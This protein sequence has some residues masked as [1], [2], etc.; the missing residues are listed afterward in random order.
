VVIGSFRACGV[1]ARLVERNRRSGMPLRVMSATG[2]LAGII[3]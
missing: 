1:P 2:G 3:E